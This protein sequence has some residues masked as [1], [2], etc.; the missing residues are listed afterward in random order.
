MVSVYKPHSE[1]DGNLVVLMHSSAPG[2]QPVTLMDESGRVL[3]RGRYVGRTNGGRPTYRFSR[4]GHAYRGSRVAINAGGQIF[5]IGNP[6]LRDE[7]VRPGSLG[8]VYDS[9]VDPIQA[10]QREGRPTQARPSTSS[11]VAP[12]NP[13]LPA[14]SAVSPLLT[15]GGRA[16]VSDW[17]DSGFT[18]LRNIGK[19]FSPGPSAP[20]TAGLFGNPNVTPATMT[21]GGG[22]IGAINAFA[23]AA[24]L[25]IAGKTLFDQLRA[26]SAEEAFESNFAA[27]YNSDKPID[28]SGRNMAGGGGRGNVFMPASSRRISR[29]SGYNAKKQGRK[30]PVDVGNAIAPKETVDN[31]VFVKDGKPYVMLAADNPLND[32]V[33]AGIGGRKAIALNNYSRLVPAQYNKTEAYLGENRG[34]K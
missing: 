1:G 9:T 3:D 29:A 12:R 20:S 18:S 24:I 14:A 32:G 11:P 21:G 31:S 33:N 2:N 28:I 27:G 30:G 6:A 16:K 17:L 5:P 10:A 26:P 25:G 4:P 22:A 34:G 8:A 23:P 13:L 19:M 15:E 7:N